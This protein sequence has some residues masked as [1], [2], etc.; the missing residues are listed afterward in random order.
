MSATWGSDAGTKVATDSLQGSWHPLQLDTRTEL[1]RSEAAE[2]LKRATAKHRNALWHPFRLERPVDP[3]GPPVVSGL[4]AYVRPLL[5][6]YLTQHCAG[7]RLLFASFNVWQTTAR[8]A[9]GTIGAL[10]FLLPYMIAV[11]PLR[12]VF[13]IAI[14]LVAVFVTLISY[15]SGL[16]LATGI[17]VTDRRILRIGTLLPSSTALFFAKQIADLG[18]PAFRERLLNYTLYPRTG[19]AEAMAVELQWARG[20]E[21]AEEVQGM[22]NYLIKVATHTFADVKSDDV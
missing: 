22:C 21:R 20:T 3:L 6:Q 10:L 13:P 9:E 15:A 4:P 5:D 11:P 12:V 16:A 19:A 14:P 8:L 7:E 17:A 1:T 18:D 2:F